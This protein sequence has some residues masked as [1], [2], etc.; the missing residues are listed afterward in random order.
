MKEE[1]SIVIDLFYIA[2]NNP[3]DISALSLS[4]LLPLQIN[5]KKRL[6]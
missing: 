6:V 5:Q 3:E 1:R 2:K 4:G